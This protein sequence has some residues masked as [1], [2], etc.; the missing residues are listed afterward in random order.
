MEYIA[1]CRP[2]RKVTCVEKTGW[3]GGSYVLNG[4]VIGGETGTVIFQAARSSKNDFRVSGDTREWMKHVGRYCAGNS[5]LVFCVSLAFAAP[6][7]TL[8]GMGG[9]G[10]HLKG[11]STDGKTTTMKVAASVCGGPELLENVACDGER[12]LEGIALRRNDAVLRTCSTRSARLTVKRPAVLLTCWVTAR[13]RQGRGWMEAR[14]NRRS[15]RFYFS[16]LAR[17]PLPSMRKQAGERRTGAGVGVR[18]VQ[19]PS[20]TGQF[21][22]FEE[23][24]GFGGGKAFA[25]HLE[26]ASRQYHGAYSATGCAG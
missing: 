20:N 7:L 22:A 24:H 18:M 6:L 11:E 2:V 21:G 25:E 4:E 3:Y 10:Y 9:G 16:P 12:A 23:L 1:T 13:V 5:R 14:V 8:L 19:I 15:G 26:Q 17:S